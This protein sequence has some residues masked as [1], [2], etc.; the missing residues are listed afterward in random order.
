MQSRAKLPAKR[1]PQ[2]R[3]ARQTALRQSGLDFDAVDST[4]N[5]ISDENDENNDS[6]SE[7]SSEVNANN[8]LNAAASSARGEVIGG[9]SDNRE[10]TAESIFS[11]NMDDKSDIGSISKESSANKNTLLS[12]STDEEDLF[13]VPLDLP[14]DAPKEESLFGRA[15]ILSPVDKDVTLE[16]T[17][18]TSDVIPAKKSFS[19]PS[20]T[21]EGTDD[22]FKSAEEGDFTEEDILPKTCEPVEKE[23]EEIKREDS[24]VAGEKVAG[25]TIDPLRDND[26]DP[27]VDPSQ[28]F[29]FVTKTPSPE[30]GKKLLLQEDDDSLFNS[31]AKKSSAKTTKQSAVDLFDD[32]EPEGDLFTTSLVS[33]SMKVRSLK[34]SLFDNDTEDDSLFGTTTAKQQVPKEQSERKDCTPVVRT[35]ENIPEASK[36]PLGDS[37]ED[38]LFASAESFNKKPD[39]SQ[40]RERLKPSLFSSETSSKIGRDVNVKKHVSLYADNDDE[41][42]FAKPTK[43][44]AT[45]TKKAV[46]KNLKSTAEKISEDPLQK[47]QED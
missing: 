26:R 7:W 8:V 1:R 42:I 20:E 46:L 3:R 18:P 31:S 5:E 33:K 41:D 28:L 39:N 38:D 21:S 37:D 2:S 40:D 19:Q 13:D 9:P 30:K 17:S 25:S 6:Q 27:L 22:I 44:S 24:E 16:K 36:F 35:V 4:R 47:M 45:T 14:E 43:I 23:H 32:A 29:A 12:P 15:P 34:S 11:L 10:K